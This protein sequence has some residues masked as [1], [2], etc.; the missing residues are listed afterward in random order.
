MVADIGIDAI[1][2][3][4]FLKQYCQN[5][6]LKNGKLSWDEGLENPTGGA[7]GGAGTEIFCCRV[8]VDDTVVIAPGGEALIAGKISGELEP[9]R[10]DTALLEPAESFAERH[11]LMIAK[12]LVDPRQDTVPLRVFNPS[13]EPVKVYRGTVAAV[14]TEAEEVQSFE[15][16]DK[17]EDSYSVEYRCR[18]CK[19]R[20][21]D[22]PSLKRHLASE[23]RIGRFKCGTCP[24]STDRRSNLSRHRDRCHRPYE[25]PGPSR[26]VVVETIKETTLGEDG[27]PLPQPCKRTPRLPAYAPHLENLLCP[28]PPLDEPSGVEGQSPSSPPPTDATDNPTPVEI[29]LETSSDLP[30]PRLFVTTC[31]PHTQ[32]STADQELATIRSA[33]REL[34]ADATSC[35]WKVVRIPEGKTHVFITETAI[36]PDGTIFRATREQ[37][38]H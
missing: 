21:C 1:L 31:S 36:H 19:Q 23:H 28:T 38:T 13:P 6:D 11:G 16:A 10:C 18:Q 9:K 32:T 12:L 15:G 35:V 37:I 4:D 20:L 30:D 14:L 3:L 24:Y 27:D 7:D 25:R 2:G 26:E 34:P 29:P 33:S 5:L 22:L 8:T 17:D